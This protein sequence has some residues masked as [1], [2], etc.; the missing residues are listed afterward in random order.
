MLNSFKYVNKVVT[1]LREVAASESRMSC[2]KNFFFLLEHPTLQ[3]IRASVDLTLD[4]GEPIKWMKK[5]SGLWPNAG[6]PMIDSHQVITGCT[7]PCG[8]LKP[9]LLTLTA[10]SSPNVSLI[11]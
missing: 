6:L 7:T 3:R 8:F 11:Q 1:R 9:T 5:V 10:S 4:I 2:V